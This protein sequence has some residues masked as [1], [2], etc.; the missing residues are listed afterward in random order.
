MIALTA[1][2]FA[3]AMANSAP[4]QE[5]GKKEEAVVAP[6][7]SG[8][9]SLVAPKSGETNE[10]AKGNQ[11]NEMLAR[12]YTWRMGGEVKAVNLQTKTISIHQETVRHDR[13]VTLR[14]DEK[15][16]KEISDLKSGDLVNVWV[17]GGK[18]TKLTEV[19]G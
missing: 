14:I 10:Q 13:V 6:Q 18:V 9:K 2:L 19:S 3:L 11:K 4:A 1:V 17:R 7:P 15:M 5:K 8:E 16:M 12:P